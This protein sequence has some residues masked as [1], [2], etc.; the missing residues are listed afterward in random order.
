M[1]LLAE[2][3]AHDALMEPVYARAN[4]QADQDANKDGQTLRDDIQRAIRVRLASYCTEEEIA[5]A[6][7]SACVALSDSLDTHKP[8][9]V[10][11]LGSNWEG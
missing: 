11:V 7:E 10:G 4:E 6:I 9:S 2:K 3:L 5:D 1:T 8:L